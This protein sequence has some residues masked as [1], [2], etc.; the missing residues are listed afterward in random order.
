MRRHGRGRAR[1]AVVATLVAVLLG[2]GLPDATAALFTS[3]ATGTHEVKGQILADYTGLGGPGG[4]L[5][6]PTTDELGTPNGKGRYNLFQRGGI[7]WTPSTG[8]HGILGAI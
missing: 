2:I 3:K 1:T 5:G 7:Y 6:Y 8:A 4:P